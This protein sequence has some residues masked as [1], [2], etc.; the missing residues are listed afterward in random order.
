M[1]LK[2]IADDGTELNV[3]AAGGSSLTMNL[4]GR[5]SAT[6]EAP[7]AGALVSGWVQAIVP[8]GVIGYAVFRQSVAGRL[9]QEAVVPL[10]GTTTSMTTLLFDLCEVV[11]NVERD[12]ETAVAE[13]IEGS[14]LHITE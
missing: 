14:Q 2:F 1:A 9:A 12:A 6:L 8:E 4:A 5:G 11:R 13:G 10:S 7:D 3:P